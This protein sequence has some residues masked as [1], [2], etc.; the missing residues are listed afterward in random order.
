MNGCLFQPASAI[1]GCSCDASHYYVELAIPLSV[2]SSS[3]VS[4]QQREWRWKSLHSWWLGLYYQQK[5]KIV[6]LYTRINLRGS[7]PGRAKMNNDDNN[8]RRIEEG[9]MTARNRLLTVMQER[10]LFLTWTTVHGWSEVTIV[11]STLWRSPFDI[12]D[13]TRS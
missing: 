6:L 7:V 8:K 11:R 5:T 13:S 1:S 2:S 3:Q 9:G 4:S 10:E 12:F